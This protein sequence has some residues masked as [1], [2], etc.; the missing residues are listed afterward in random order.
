V[1]TNLGNKIMGGVGTY[2]TACMATSGILSAITGPGAVFMATLDCVPQSLIAA[3]NASINYGA[4]TKAFIDRLDPIIKIATPVMIAATALRGG[5]SG[6]VRGIFTS[7]ATA[8]SLGIGLPLFIDSFGNDG[9]SKESYAEDFRQEQER[10]AETFVASGWADYMEGVETFTNIGFLTG[11]SAKAARIGFMPIM[12]EVL[13]KANSSR[14]AQS[15]ADIL[16][17]ADTIGKLGVAGN[18]AKASFIENLKITLNSSIETTPGQTVRKALDPA[19]AG[20]E[21][22]MADRAA[23]KILGEVTDS[24]DA[25]KRAASELAGNKL[26]ST[27]FSGESFR[28]RAM[29]TVGAEPGRPLPQPPPGQTWGSAYEEYLKNMKKYSDSASR[30]WKAN[31]KKALAETQDAT[32]NKIVQRFDDMGAFEGSPTMSRNELI[33]KAS[34]AIDAEKTLRGTI[35]QVDELS[36]I[37]RVTADPDVGTLMV[38]ASKNKSDALKGFLRKAG[39][40]DNIEDV[41]QG[42]KKLKAGRLNILRNVATGFGIAI[43]AHLTGIAAWDIWWDEI[44]T[45][46]LSEEEKVSI[47]GQEF[48]PS[49]VLLNKPIINL[50]ELTNFTTYKIV[51]KKSLTGRITFSF[52]PVKKEAGYKE[53]QEYLE[54][55]PEKEWKGDCAKFGSVAAPKILGTCSD[56]LIPDEGDGLDAWMWAAYYDNQE[57][58]YAASRNYGIPQYM[59]MAVLATNPNKII[60]TMPPNWYLEEETKRTPWIIQI[61]EAIDLAVGSK[62]LS[63]ES[64]LDVYKQKEYKELLEKKLERWNKTRC[65][66]KIGA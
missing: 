60:S 3:K 6:G 66:V 34:N 32:V 49:E 65:E 27:D 8:G 4:D 2:F 25:L 18:T 13:T 41:S 45:P 40:N 55:N 17:D 15:T 51:A 54:K 50:E 63:D 59:I 43:A 7:R 46:D 37:K 48:T 11:Q 22:R 1:K 21:T 30:K 31:Y 52:Y 19:M 53:M 38:R 57:T 10:L 29:A 9:R 14:V 24:P 62:E 26:P 16:F 23:G 56:T 20:A 5:F 39:V 35:D 47:G 42:V 12:D 58:L 61:A 33:N 64:I 36:V 44:V 28:A